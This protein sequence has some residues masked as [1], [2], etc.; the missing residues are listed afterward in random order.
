MQI[1]SQT[2]IQYICSSNVGLGY[3]VYLPLGSTAGAS[4]LIYRPTIPSVWVITFF[5]FPLVGITDPKFC[6]FYK[7]GPTRALWSEL[8]TMRISYNLQITIIIL[9]MNTSDNTILDKESICL[10][11][12]VMAYHF[13]WTWL[14]YIINVLGYVKQNYNKTRTNSI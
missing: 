8:V 3:C 5:F 10:I 13:N 4:F 9:R 11:F 7:N 2:A 1:P 12:V 14:S 6:M